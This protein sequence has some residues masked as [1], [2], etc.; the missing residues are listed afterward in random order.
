VTG[1]L[2]IEGSLHFRHRP[3]AGESKFAAKRRF[4]EGELSTDSARRR[5]PLT[6]EPPLRY[7]SPSPASGG[8]GKRLRA[9]VQFNALIALG[10]LMVVAVYSLTVRSA[11]GAEPVRPA[12][13]AAETEGRRHRRMADGKASRTSIARDVET[14]RAAKSDG[15]RAGRYASSLPRD[16]FTAPA[17]ATAKAV[18]SSYLVANPRTARA[19]LYCRLLGACLQSWWRVVVAALR[20]A[21]IEKPPT[22]RCA[23]RKGDRDR[24]L[25]PDRGR[26]GARLVWPRAGGFY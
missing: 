3:A 14:I 11:R 13:A 24:Q 26:S 22:K 6:Q 25:R 8:E 18:I 12:A 19:A 15:R 5:V 20:L 10:V 4:G 9:P 21:I 1:K 2:R 16:L 17:P 23:G 7:A